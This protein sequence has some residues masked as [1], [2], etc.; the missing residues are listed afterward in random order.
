MGNTTFDKGVEHFFSKVGTAFM[1][2]LQLEILRRIFDFGSRPGHDL[3]L[4]RVFTDNLFNIVVEF[5]I[6]IIREMATDRHVFER[7]FGI[8]QGSGFEARVASGE[9]SAF[10][11][12][13]GRL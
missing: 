13:Y 10:R 6:L 7:G 5:I 1:F 8:F 9:L 12:F 11:N 3:E 4:L 2:S